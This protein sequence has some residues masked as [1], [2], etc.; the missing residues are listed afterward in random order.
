MTLNM[1]EKQ[2]QV[3]GSKD[4]QKVTQGKT[5]TKQKSIQGTLEPHQYINTN[6]FNTKPRWHKVMWCSR[7]LILYNKSTLLHNLNYMA[8]QL[9]CQRCFTV[10]FI[11]SIIKCE[12]T[13]SNVH[14]KE[15]IILNCMELSQNST[16][17]S[18]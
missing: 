11:F 17:H 15:S 16:S 4:Y 7:E 3:L 1:K 10:L 13:D 18:Q 2:G 9:L 8:L 6:S 5:T 14:H 12:T